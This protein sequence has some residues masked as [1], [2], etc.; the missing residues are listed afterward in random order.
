MFTIPHQANHTNIIKWTLEL[1]CCTL[2]NP[3]RRSD[4]PIKAPEHIPTAHDGPMLDALRIIESLQ[5]EGARLGAIA[6]GASLAIGLY[7][8]AGCFAVAAGAFAYLT[9]RSIERSDEYAR[10]TRQQR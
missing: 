8:L 1:L 7:P 6:C 2:S 10:L 9:E 4:I 3:Q 5:Y